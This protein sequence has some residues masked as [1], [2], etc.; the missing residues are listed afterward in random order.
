[1]CIL[2]LA[3]SEAFCVLCDKAGDIFKQLFCTSCGRHY[4]GNC[5][6]PP[7]AISSIVRMGW[8]CPECKVCQ[9]CR[10]VQRKINLVF[11]IVGSFFAFI[12]DSLLVVLI[13]LIFIYGTLLVIHSAISEAFLMS[14]QI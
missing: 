1:M 2:L 13:S 8:Q 6:D 12:A 3:G 14:V 9:G 10:Y 4:H 11:V 7:V 5:L